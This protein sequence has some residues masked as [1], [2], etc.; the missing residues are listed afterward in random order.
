MST[1]IVSRRPTAVGDAVAIHHMT[2]LG[3]SYDHQAFDGVT[4][5]RFLARIRDTPQQR[6]W[7]AE[8]G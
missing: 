3:L 2:I 1:N 6:N 7:E 5:S 4:A 8:L